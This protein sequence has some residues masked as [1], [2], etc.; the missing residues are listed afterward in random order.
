MPKTVS[1]PLLPAPEGT[2]TSVY[3]V[4]HKE[5]GD[6]N[7]GAGFEQ[8]GSPI[9]I[10]NLKEGVSYQAEI[11]RRCCDG[12]TSSPLLVSFTVPTGE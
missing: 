8:L 7:F 1:I 12:L 5:A 2:C 6:A 10:A 3:Q 11:T 9:Q 4:R